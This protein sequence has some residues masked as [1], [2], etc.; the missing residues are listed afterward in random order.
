MLVVNIVLADKLS[1]ILERNDEEA[2]SQY[3]K[4]ISVLIL[5]CSLLSK[6]PRH[7]S[8]YKSHGLSF[9]NDFN[10]IGSQNMTS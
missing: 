1:L 7:C 3:D 5:F 4:I 2:I 6:Q 9:T 8:R 10:T